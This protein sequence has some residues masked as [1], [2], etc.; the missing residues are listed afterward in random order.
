MELEVRTNDIL[1]ASSKLLLGVCKEIWLVAAV[2]YNIATS[3]RVRLEIFCKR[4]AFSREYSFF[5]SRVELSLLGIFDDVRKLSHEN[6]ILEYSFF[7]HVWSCHFLEYMMIFEN[8][9]LLNSDDCY[10]NLRLIMFI[11]SC[12]EL[13]DKLIWPY[14]EYQINVMIW[15]ISML[16]LYPDT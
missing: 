7:F 1:L 16:K 3:L 14:L 5:F 8:S 13:R 2:L 6:L 9:Q 10:V 12:F 15:F 11:S 4:W